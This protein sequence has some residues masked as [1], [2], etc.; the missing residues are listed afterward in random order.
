[1]KTGTTGQT[2]DLTAGRKLRNQF[3]IFFLFVTISAVVWVFIKLSRDFSSTITYQVNYRNIPVGQILINASDTAIVVGLDAQG[4]DLVKYHLRK[5]KAIIDIDLS[6]IRLQ[7]AG[8]AFNGYI[9]T[10]GLTRKVATQL[11][12]HNELIFIAPDTLKFVFMPEYKRF[13]PVIA[14]VQYQLRPQHMLYDSVRIKPDSIWVFGPKSIVDTISSVFSEP[15][16]VNDLQEDYHAV[17]KLQKPA[18]QPLTYSSDIT[19][20]VFRVE[21][22]TERAIELPIKIDCQE[23]GL[24]LRIFP[25]KATIHCFVALKDYKRIDDAMFEAAVICRPGELQQGSKLRVEV[26]EH[27]S[28]VRIARIEPERVEYLLVKPSQ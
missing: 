1:M 14:Q 8:N 2:H 9:L 19:D 16:V 12:S 25:E 10:S 18:G 23:A 5:N 24:A 4:F 28:W 27:P 20:I 21:K 11:G 6:G 26:R 7:P 13:L 15:L 3:S 17:L 22:F